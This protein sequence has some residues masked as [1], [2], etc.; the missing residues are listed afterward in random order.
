[1]KVKN[2]QVGVSMI[3]MADLPL[4][5]IAL[6]GGLS[7]TYA[8][9][10]KLIVSIFVYIFRLYYVRKYIKFDITDY[11]RK[12]IQ[13]CIMVSLLSLPIPLFLQEMST[14][15]M[16]TI[17]LIVLNEIIVCLLIIFVGL[18]NDERVFFKQSSVKIAKKLLR[19]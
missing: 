5:V 2:Y 1:M 10:I 14:S 9:I 19:K 17:S 18:D 11:L 16:S 13:P 15:I 3:I 8:F 4:T 12:V 6:K 7:P